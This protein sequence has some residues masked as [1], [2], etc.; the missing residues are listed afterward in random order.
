MTSALHK[1]REL[2]KLRTSDGCLQIGSL[3]KK[4]VTGKLKEVA[5]QKIDEQTEALVSMIG[6]GESQARNKYT[7]FASVAKKEG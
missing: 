5:Y 6:A 7:Y 3:S 1:A 4:L 2:I